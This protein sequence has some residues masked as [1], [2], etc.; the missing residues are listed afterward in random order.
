MVAR[1]CSRSVKSSISVCHCWRLRSTAYQVRST[2]PWW[3]ARSRCRSPTVRWSPRHRCPQVERRSR[4][5]VSAE[6]R[7]DA[8]GGGRSRMRR[9]G[10]TGPRRSRTLYGALED[11]CQRRHAEG[12]LAFVAADALGCPG[13]AAC[14]GRDVSSRR[15]TVGVQPVGALPAAGVGPVWTMRAE[16]RHDRR[17]RTAAVLWQLRGDAR[18]GPVGQRRRWS[19]ARPL[20][21]WRVERVRVCRDCN[22]LTSDKADLLA[23]R[24]G[25]RVGLRL[26]ML[27]TGQDPGVPDESHPKTVARTCLPLRRTRTRLVRR[28][29]G[30]SRP[31]E[32]CLVDDRP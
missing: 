3:S 26:G 9:T 30:L 2:G 28:L 21:G 29:E 15:F 8:C 11:A 19:A 14:G 23:S 12:S 4:S 16:P 18:T 1:F 6:V 31:S 22:E 32:V 7:Q 13:V 20:Q 5:A 10:A 27:V 25:K 17:S 24:C